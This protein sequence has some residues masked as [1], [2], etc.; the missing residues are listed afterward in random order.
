MH[1][2]FEKKLQEAAPMFLKDLGGDEMQ[3]CMALGICCGDGWYNAL[4]ELF[5]LIEMLNK[6][7]V[8]SGVLICDQVKTKYGDLCVYWHYEEQGNPVKPPEY[9]KDH[10][11]K[12]L[13]VFEDVCDCTCEM[14]GQMYNPETRKRT[15]STLCPDCEELRAKYGVWDKPIP[16]EE[17][18]KQNPEKQAQKAL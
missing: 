1:P 16:E 18:K 3:T 7:L 14:C 4:K 13:E 11:E 2:E 17:N 15:F 9:V 8:E 6:R 10:M 12:L 5:F